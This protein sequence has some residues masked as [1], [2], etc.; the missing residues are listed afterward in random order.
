MGDVL[1]PLC[2]DTGGYLPPPLCLPQVMQHTSRFSRTIPK[3]AYLFHIVEVHIDGHFINFEVITIEDSYYNYYRL[4]L[5]LGNEA[6]DS[7]CC[8]IS[9]AFC[10]MMLLPSFSYSSCLD[11]FVRSSVC[12]FL[13]A[14]LIGTYGGH[15][16]WSG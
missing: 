16:G 8:C 4:S 14:E 10:E 12:N 5:I 11:C 1:C 3:F 6:L 15:E 9:P 2:G 7:I 13:F